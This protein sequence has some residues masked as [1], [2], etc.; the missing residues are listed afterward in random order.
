MSGLVWAITMLKQVNSS[1]TVTGHP[2]LKKRW[3]CGVITAVLFD[4][5][6]KA[7]LSAS[8]TRR[9][10][11]SERYTFEMSEPA[12]ANSVSSRSRTL[13]MIHR[14]RRSSSL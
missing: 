4:F 1:A 13:Y 12:R 11:V 9:T 3:P 7:T 14:K 5:V 6:S 10:F 8:H 2:K